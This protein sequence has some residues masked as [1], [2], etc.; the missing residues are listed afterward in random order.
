LLNW[1]ASV[2]VAEDVL[3]FTQAR[4]VETGFGPGDRDRMTSKDAEP[5][6]TN[7]EGEVIDKMREL[8]G[9][10]LE[11]VAAGSSRGE[12]AGVLAIA[13][14]G[15]W[16]GSALGLLELLAGRPWACSSVLAWRRQ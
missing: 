3:Q 7:D 9:A 13:G 10:E 16:V 15:A 5:A 6:M 14:Y 2:A 11:L 8:T 12:T 4:A 1:K